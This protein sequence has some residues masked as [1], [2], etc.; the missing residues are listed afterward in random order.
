MTFEKDTSVPACRQMVVWW[1]GEAGLKLIEEPSDHIIMATLPESATLR[2]CAVLYYPLGPQRARQQEAGS[3]QKAAGSRK[4]AAGSQ[5]PLRKWRLEEVVFE[6]G[7][8]IRWIQLWQQRGEAGLHTQQLF[9]NNGASKIPLQT[10]NISLCDLPD[11][12]VT[13]F[14]LTVVEG[15][16]VTVTCNGSGSPLPEVDWTV[17]D[18]HSIN[19]HQSNVYWPNV[20]SINLT[21]VNVSRDDN[22]YMLTCIAENKVG[23]ANTSIQLTVHCT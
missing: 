5:G 4:Q 7:C 11:I 21:L 3:R 10:M 18:L 14:N 6:C 20:H 23:M 15:D 22:F 19:T 17:N 9:C 1:C 16:R 8:D 2:A 12:S 13:H